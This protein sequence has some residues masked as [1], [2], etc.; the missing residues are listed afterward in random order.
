MKPQGKG[1]RAAKAKKAAAAKVAAAKKAQA[2]KVSNA[3]RPV[4][5]PGGTRMSRADAAKKKAARRKK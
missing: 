3:K 1:G 4:V 5:G 2:D